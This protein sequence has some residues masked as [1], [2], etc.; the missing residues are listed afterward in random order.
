M[1]TLDHNPFATRFTRPGGVEYLFPAGVAAES[2]VATLRT[3]QW[4]GEIIGPHGTGKSTLL[5]LL[6]PELQRAGRTV[7]SGALRQGER[8]LPFSRRDEAAWSSNT[9]VVI[10]GYEQ[11]SWWSKQRLKRVVQRQEAGLLITAHAPMGLPSLWTTQPSL[12]LAQA[13]VERL[14]SPEDQT[15]SA[16][17]VAAAFEQHPTN[18]REMI[19]ALFDVWQARQA[20]A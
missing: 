10:D 9:Q 2:V 4:Q 16:A 5:A 13:I 12:Q 20:K 15:I 14:V 18:L 11:L 1:G 17:D 6:V 3:N 8:S 7:V 19:F